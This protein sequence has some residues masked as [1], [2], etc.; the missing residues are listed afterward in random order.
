MQKGGNRGKKE[1]CTIEKRLRQEH[2]KEKKD[3]VGQ[4]KKRGGGFSAVILTKRRKEG[5]KRRQR[6]KRRRKRGGGGG[7]EVAGRK[8]RKKKEKKNESHGWGKKKG[9]CS[10][11]GNAGKK[12]GRRGNVD[13]RLRTR[14]DDHTRGGGGERKKGGGGGGECTPYTTFEITKRKK[15]VE[16][17]TPRGK[18]EKKNLPPILR[19]K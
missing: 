18:R 19:K 10:L 3:A 11:Y 4:R 2:T 5:E 9:T 1:G 12:G 15:K 8:P 13:V 16:G 6:G 17:K 14:F 7:E